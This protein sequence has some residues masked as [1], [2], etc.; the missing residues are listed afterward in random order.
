MYR[1]P[2]VMTAGEASAWIDR[3]LVGNELQAAVP[4]YLLVL[5]RPDQVPFELQQVLAGAFSVGR[6]GFDADAGYEAYVDKLV[7][8]PR[9]PAPPRAVYFTWRDGTAAMEL[10]HRL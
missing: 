8:R 5:G 1:V 4:G 6:V 9:A 2:P 3:K 10:G 7:R